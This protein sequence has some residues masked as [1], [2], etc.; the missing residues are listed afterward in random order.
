MRYFM[1]A[2]LGAVST[3]GVAVGSDRIGDW[4]VS[5]Y[6]N[7]MHVA[8]TTNEAGASLGV[9]CFLDSQECAAFIITTNSCKDGAAVP[10]M[11]NTATGADT[12][13]TVCRHI[14][15]DKSRPPLMMNVVNEFGTMKTAFANGGL[16]GV[17]IPMANG[18]FHVLRFSTGGASR[19]IAEAMTLPPGAESKGQP[20]K[21]SAY[22]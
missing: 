3:L 13:T 5:K 6:G 7:S 11:L 21:A 8:E 4:V 16:V 15:T 14:S 10:M 19:A 1:A 12:I 17:A 20:A 22:Y 2:F 9:M 18:A